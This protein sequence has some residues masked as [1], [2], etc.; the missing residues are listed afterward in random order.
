MNLQEMKLWLEETRLSGM[1]TGY[2]TLRGLVDRFPNGSLTVIGARPA[3]GRY[4]LALNL[5]NRI[6]RLTNRS[7]AISTPAPNRRRRLTVF[8]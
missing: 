6:A 5:A 4:S 1:P 3:M 7:I 2:D 8:P